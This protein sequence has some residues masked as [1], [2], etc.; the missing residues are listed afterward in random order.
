MNKRKGLRVSEHEWR[1]TTH[2]LK[3]CTSKKKS[4]SV[5]TM[6]KALLVVL[7]IILYLTY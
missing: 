2:S 4:L 1:T 3:N 6:A 5:W 7:P